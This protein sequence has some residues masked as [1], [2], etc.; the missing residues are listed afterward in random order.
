VITDAFAEQPLITTVQLNEF[1][2]PL[3]RTP[4][5]G[6]NRCGGFGDFIDIL[7]D[8]YGRPWF[9]LSHNIVDE[10]IYGSMMLGP[11]LRGPVTN[12]TALPVGGPQTLGG[13]P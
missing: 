2:D 13:S 7:I 12:L 3:D 4:G 5:C 6:Y 11:T 8:Q 10:G 1:G 9:G